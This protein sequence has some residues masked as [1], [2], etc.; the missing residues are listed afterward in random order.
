M[1]LLSAK[2]M[3]LLV[4]GKKQCNFS[5]TIN[6]IRLRFRE[7]FKGIGLITGF[8]AIGKSNLIAIII[9]S[10]LFGGRTSI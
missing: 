9:P 6:S 5:T 4:T 3:S 2:T 1:L 8:A 7:L 10:F